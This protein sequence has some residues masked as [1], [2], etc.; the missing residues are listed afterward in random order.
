MPEL[1]TPDT[2]RPFDAGDADDP[3]AAAL[4]VAVALLAIAL[5]VTAIAAAVAVDP[6]FG[7]TGALADRDAVVALAV[8]TVL[9]LAV[10]A[11]AAVAAIAAVL[12]LAV[13]AVLA[14]ADHRSDDGA[15]DTATLVVAAVI[16][17]GLGGGGGRNAKHRET[18][19]AG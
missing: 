14:T 1:I 15:D 11:V 18:G 19:H 2:F 9:A 16:S 6:E 10:A 4:I 3:G 8:G 17:I 12:A 5:V 13:G 7:C